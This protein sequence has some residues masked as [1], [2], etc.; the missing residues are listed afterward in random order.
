[1]RVLGIEGSCDETA[2]CVPG[3]AVLPGLAVP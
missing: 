3:L 1:M 2:A